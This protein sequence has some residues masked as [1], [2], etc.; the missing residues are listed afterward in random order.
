M[1]AL[2]LSCTTIIYSVYF[3]EAYKAYKKGDE[4][5]KPKPWLK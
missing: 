3:I 1:T 2:A 4:C 5:Q